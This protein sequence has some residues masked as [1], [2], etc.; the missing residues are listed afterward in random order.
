[1]PHFRIGVVPEAAQ[2]ARDLHGT[3][4][5][6]EQLERDGS[7]LRTEAR[8]LGEAEQLLQF[9]GGEDRAV[10]A[11]VELRV[12]SRGEGNGQWREPV[13]VAIA[14]RERDAALRERINP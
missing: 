14:A 6:R 7:L 12:A 2:V 8:R 5:R 1:L 3:S 10:V 9:H 4:V 11:I 13:E